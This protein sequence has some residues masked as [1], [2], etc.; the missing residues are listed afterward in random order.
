MK[1]CNICKTVVRDDA[2]FC[3][4]CGS[5]IQ[6]LEEII[7]EKR[8]QLNIEGNLDCYENKI[9]NSSLTINE[10]KRERDK[11]HVLILIGALILLL[12]ITFISFIPNAKSDENIH[13]EYKIIQ[14]QLD[15]ND[16]KGA[17]ENIDKFLQ[18]HDDSKYK[19][20]LSKI[21]DDI[22][23][24]I[25]ILSPNFNIE[26]GLINTGLTDNKDIYE[27][28]SSQLYDAVIKLNM[29]KEKIILMS[30]ITNSKGED[31]LSFSYNAHKFNAVYDNDNRLLYIKNNED[32]KVYEDGQVLL[33]IGSFTVSN[34]EMVNLSKVSKMIVNLVH[35]EPTI[36]KFP[37]INEN[38]SSW[39][40]TC[41]DNV[42][43]ITSNVFYV[44]NH[45][46]GVY[47]NF[48]IVLVRDGE[49]YKLLDL[50]INGIK[51]SDILY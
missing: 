29:N 20:E 35:E 7:N 45:S 33:D 36:S 1:K 30:L 5:R 27:N 47:E 9:D 25:K 46:V 32:D 28:I 22:L 37:D 19:E 42:I 15:K 4:F 17:Y 24:K 49:G 3:T 34:E 16:Y 18:E 14:S 48:K 6:T 10:D 8:N 31:I 50:I 51:S 13:R 39:N 40:I 38:Q 12:L 43:T 21:K 26:S 2:N 23:D 44:N 11:I 41:K